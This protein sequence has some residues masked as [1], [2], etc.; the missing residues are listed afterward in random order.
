M[1]QTNEN[2]QFARV[3]EKIDPHARLVRTWRLE[4]GVSAR[5]TGLEV[6][7]GDG[8]PRKLLVR[9]HGARDLAQNPRV[10][11]MEFKLLQL[12]HAQGLSVP[13]PY[14]LEQSGETLSTPFIVVAYIEGDTE[15]APTDL[16]A[17]LSQFA[18]YLA[19][20]HRVDAS[21]LAL[22]LLPLQEERYARKLRERPA[23]TDETLDEGR[24]RDVLEAVWPVAQ[25]NPA[26]LLHGDFW[27]GNALWREGQLAAVVDWEDA[28][29]GDPLADLGNSRLEIL[30]AFGSE[31]M[32]D[33]TR[34]YHALNPV[35]LA[36][37]PYWDLCA[38]LRPAFQIDKWAADAD[39]ARTLR[40][41]HR[42]FITRAFGILAARPSL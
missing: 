35:D 38:A 29:L 25:H 31:A 12:L 2:A 33:F 8:R 36:N 4:G 21:R 41:K 13:E 6:E 39:A 18:A 10:A 24:I 17:F 26:V 32:Q 30:W 42:W 3:M 34:R 20:L 19:T 5:V 22:P 1:T 23:R 7:Q 40:E 37:L 16:P 28:A 15:F 9:Q 14:Y 11:A 27:P